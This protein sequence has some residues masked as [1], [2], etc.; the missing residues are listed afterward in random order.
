MYGLGSENKDLPGFVVLL[1]GENN[2]G[3]G[4]SCWGSGFLPTVHQ[5]VEFRSKGEPVLFVRLRLTVATDPARERPALAQASVDINGDVLHAHVTG[6]E[7]RE[8][9]DLLQRRLL[10]QLE[11]R[12]S[13]RR[14]RRRRGSTRDATS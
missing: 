12:V 11:Q 8:A 4:K 7:L 14:A 1:S 5:G 13:H 6:H 2:P 3:G 10:D 9:A